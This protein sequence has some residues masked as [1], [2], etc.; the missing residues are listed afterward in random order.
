LLKRLRQSA[1]EQAWAQFA[2]RYTPLIWYWA[3]RWGLQ[4]QDAADLVQD[5]WLIL[6][7]KLPQFSVLRHKSFRGWLRKVTLNKWRENRRRAQLPR[8]P[9][10]LDA[11]A[12][13]GGDNVQDYRED[14]H[15]HWLAVRALEV[16]QAEFEPASWRA[17][18]NMVVAGHS[19]AQVAQ[20]LGISVGAVYVAKFRVL[21][22]LRQELHAFRG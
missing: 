21:A 7:R 5:V 15:R 22:R 20:Q 2:Q 11:A 4:E 3:R 17:F 6:L 19:A 13:A 12:L 10:P 18:W 16:M 1:D 8:E 9:G 14:E